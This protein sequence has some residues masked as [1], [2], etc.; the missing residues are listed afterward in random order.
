MDFLG[1]KLERSLNH[2]ALGCDAI[3]EDSE[4]LQ[5]QFAEVNNQLMR[6]NH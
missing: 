6:S 2:L 1:H 3:I 5:D 4:L